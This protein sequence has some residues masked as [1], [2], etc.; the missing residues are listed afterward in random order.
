MKR[1]AETELEQ[2]DKK[3]ARVQERIR[4]QVKT[5]Q[6][7]QVGVDERGL[8]FCLE[9]DRRGMLIGQTDALCERILSL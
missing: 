9:R 8:V 5:I 3:M 7:C 4:V 2:A 6:G 1:K